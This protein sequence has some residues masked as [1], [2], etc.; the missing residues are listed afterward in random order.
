M[1]ILIGG[2][3]PVKKFLDG[4]NVVR[5]LD[6]DLPI[7]GASFFVL[8]YAIRTAL[9]RNTVISGARKYFEDQITE[10]HYTRFRRW[11]AG[12]LR[13]ISGDRIDFGAKTIDVGQLSR[14]W[15]RGWLSIFI[16]TEKKSYAHYE[17]NKYQKNPSKH[18]S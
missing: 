8:A 14:I 18:Q 7:P 9:S 17:T 11:I 15:T 2:K 4:S 3:E 13:L 12:G 16:I 10:G 6:I 1:S 5:V